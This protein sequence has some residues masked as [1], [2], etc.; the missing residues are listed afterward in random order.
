MRILYF[1]L[2]INIS[3][4]GLSIAQATPVD[5]CLLKA[6]KTAAPHTTVEQLR[7]QCEAE[8]RPD[9]DRP[10]TELPSEPLERLPTETETPVRPEKPAEKQEMEVLPSLFERRALF[11]QKTRDKPWVISPH[12]PSYI[13]PVTYNLSPNEKA[14]RQQFANVGRFDG[15]PAEI[16][17][18]EVKFQFSFKLPIAYDLFNGNGSLFFAYTNQAYWQLYN[19]DL[20]SPFREINHEPELFLSLRNNWEIFDFENKLILL[21]IVHQSNGREQPFSR[22]WNRIYA[23]FLFEKDNFLLSIKPWWRIPDEEPAYPGD[24]KGDDNPDIAKYMGYGELGG[25]YV[26]GKHRFGMLLRN[27]LRSDNKGAVELTWSYPIYGKIRLYAQ[28]FNGYGESLI[29]YNHYNH[30][31]GIGISLNDWF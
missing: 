21:G 27:N 31:I 17:R 24:P 28:Y 26:R 3:L 2:S 8:E 11:E 13:L 18:Q 25:F 1:F 29:D 19:R 14:F 6:L 4:T 7:Q 12:K 10:Y 15:H 23:N 5:E 9:L 30:R 16:Q 20:S 22:G